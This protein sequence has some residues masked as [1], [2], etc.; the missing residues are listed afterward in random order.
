MSETIE[1]VETDSWIGKSMKRIEDARFLRGQGRYVGDYAA[2]G[3][4][5]IA[6]LRSPL[7]HAR[8]RNIDTSRAEAL[9]GV[10]AV[11]TGEDAKRLTNP[12]F[13]SIPDPIVQYCLAVDKVRYVGEYVAV[14]AAKDRYI[15]ED[16]ASLIDVEYE[17]LAPVVD[18]FDAMKDETLIHA[19]L[20]SNVPIRRT[21]TFGEV[22]KH[23]AEADVVVEGTFRWG[24][25]S[26]V[27]METIGAVANWDEGSQTMEVVHNLQSPMLNFSIADSLKIPTSRLK[28]I[29]S[30]IG[31]GFGI[32][33]FAP[34]AI[35]IAGM[36][37]R[38]TGRPAKFMEDRFD[39]MMNCDGHAEDRYYKASIAATKDGKLLSFKINVVDDYGA[40]FQFGPGS[41]AN[42]LSQAT[43]LY[44]IESHQYE[45][46]A[47]L[48]NK[49]QQCPYRG[50]GTPP[51]NFVLERLIDKL[52]KQIGMSL[53]DIRRKNFIPKDQFP[54]KIP[55]GNQYDSGDYEKVLDALLELSKYDELVDWA[56]AQRKQGRYVGVGISTTPDR[57]VFSATEF[58]FWYDNPPVPV[59]SAPES[60]SIKID[61]DGSFTV[62]LHSASSGTAAETVAAQIVATEFHVDP[63]RISVVNMDWQA[64]AP[65]TG[66]AGSRLTVM[67]SGA[68][69]GAADILKE[70]MLKIAAKELEV[71]R[72][73]LEF[74]FERVQVRG[75]ADRSVSIDE[76]AL[77]ANVLKMQLPDDVSTGLTQTF[78][79][80]H[81]LTTPPNDSRTDLGIFYPFMAQTMHVPVVEVDIETGMIK[82][83]EYFAVHDCGTVINPITVDGQILGA[84]CQGVGG[85]LLEEF[86]YDENGQMLSASFMDYLMP[87]AMEMPAMKV[88]H[89]ETPSPFSYRGVKGAG[90][91]GRM[92]VASALAS[93]LDDA[94]QEFGVEITE[95][96]LTPSAL[97][98][99][100]TQA[101]VARRVEESR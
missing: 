12:L 55:T 54:Y 46:T 57:S 4:I 94:L 91:G 84:T 89:T 85:A 36:V 93:A 56:E 71:D 47:V 29:P 34:K 38:V 42:T 97:L 76:I 35:V 27:P 1:R 13:R 49:C 99:K 101:K 24:R 64:G 19:E 39:H 44:T 74:A 22:D 95:L 81:P 15:A 66:P 73:D 30:D 50:F 43:G 31:G 67:L 18:P 72:D 16:A 53:V 69:S 23:Y 96:P 5:E 10:F 52:A 98:E 58:W 3:M 33:F 79:F 92:V 80:D 11:L 9:P 75:A 88:A 78:T 61:A 59:S 41:H 17:E 51:T 87:T 20:G 21:L 8:I 26:G 37:S 48:T 90:E 40:Y 83:L 100:I 63:S 70:K 62:F 68:L 45:L 82:Y 32:K 14:V 65:S 77:K 2:R 7:A 86:R 25:H 28:L 60:A 6:P